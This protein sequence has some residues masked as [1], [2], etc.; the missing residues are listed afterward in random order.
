MIYKVLET[1]S[2]K[3]NHVDFGVVDNKGRKVGCKV[4]TIK[5]DIESLPNEKAGWSS[6]L[7]DE[8]GVYWFVN[9]HLT[10]DDKQFGAS[11]QYKVFKSYNEI[12][13]YLEKRIGDAE[14]RQVKKWG[15]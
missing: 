3:T 4:T 8:S 10:R 5:K 11:Q 15:V 13:K 6:D 1:L 2:T 14:K 9:V 7:I 12:H